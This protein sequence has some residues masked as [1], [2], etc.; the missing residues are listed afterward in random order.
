M[1]ATGIHSIYKSVKNNYLMFWYVF[2]VIGGATLVYRIAYR[3]V[4]TDPY[5]QIIEIN[6]R[7]NRTYGGSF[8]CSLLVYTHVVFTKSS[9]RLPGIKGSRR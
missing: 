2:I 6:K 4:Y 5:L 8:L 7:S 3:S 9:Q 1:L